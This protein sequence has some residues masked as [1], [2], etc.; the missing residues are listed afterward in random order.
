MKGCRHSGIRIIVPP[1]RAAMPIRV[2]CRLVKPNKVVNPPPLM[3]GE[4]LAARI[5]EMGPVGATFLGWVFHFTK[6]KYPRTPI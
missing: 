3:E 4:A 2:T 1:R 5:V 6:S